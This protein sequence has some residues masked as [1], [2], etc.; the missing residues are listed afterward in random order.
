M[1][2][3]GRE[4]GQ[5]QRHVSAGDGVREAAPRRPPELAPERNGAMSRGWLGSMSEPAL[6]PLG[7]PE[8]L[9]AGS[10]VAAESGRWWSSAGGGGGV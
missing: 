5:R 10:G 4:Q 3:A 2:Q 8:G 1:V 7:P 6:L 9:A